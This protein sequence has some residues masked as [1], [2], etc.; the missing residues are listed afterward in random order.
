M[1]VTIDRERGD[2][3]G[4]ALQVIAA[5]EEEYPYR[6]FKIDVWS[7]RNSGKYQMRL[8]GLCYLRL[9]EA[10]ALGPLLERLADLHEFDAAQEAL[11]FP[12]PEAVRPIDEMIFIDFF[13]SARAADLREL[14]PLAESE[15]S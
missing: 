12:Q 13:D 14:G 2:S 10:D 8:D 9:W 6:Q 3:E 15:T 1:K 5:D 4:V 7:E 11:Q